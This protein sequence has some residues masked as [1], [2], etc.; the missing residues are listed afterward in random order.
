[1]NNEDFLTLLN[2]EKVP[3]AAGENEEWTELYH[4][5]AEIAEKEGFPEVA[6]A[7]RN[8]ATVEKEHEARYLKLLAN[9]E[10][11]NVF[12]KKNVVRWKC[13]NLGLY[14]KEMKL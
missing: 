5:F 10:S 4:D 7:Y 3:K 11:D 1:M 9:L 8:I 6:S 12:K 2:K 13:R 14:M